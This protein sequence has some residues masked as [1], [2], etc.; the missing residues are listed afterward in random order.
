MIERDVGQLGIVLHTGNVPEEEQR[1]KEDDQQSEE[2]SIEVILSRLDLVGIERLHWAFQLRSYVQIGLH[3]RHV[4]RLQFVEEVACVLPAGFHVV[5]E[6]LQIR[7]LWVLV[8]EEVSLSSQFL[9]FTFCLLIESA[10]VSWCL[11]DIAV[12]SHKM[13]LAS[14]HKIAL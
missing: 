5:L 14:H 7:H 8:L 12:S 1:V 11:V 10:L 9:L 4:A 2:V 6:F 3:S 13:P